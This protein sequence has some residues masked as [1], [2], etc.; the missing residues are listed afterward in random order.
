VITSKTPSIQQS[1]ARRLRLSSDEALTFI[2][3]QLVRDIKRLIGRG[4]SQSGLEAHLLQEVLL[5]SA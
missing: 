3:N 5:T 1:P 2:D 4:Q